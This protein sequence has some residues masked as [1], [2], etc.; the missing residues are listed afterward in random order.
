MT[1]PDVP[2]AEVPLVAGGGCRPHG[3]DRP[4]RHLRGLSGVGRPALKWRTS[5]RPVHHYR[6]RRGRRQIDAA[7]ACWRRRSSGPGSPVR[8]TRE[9]GG[10]PGAEAIR[11]LLL[12]GEGERWDAISEALLLTAARRDHVARVIAR[13]SRK[14]VWVVSRPVSPIRRWPIRVTAKGCRS[15]SSLHCSGFALGDLSARPDRDPRSA[16][17]NRARPRCRALGRRPLRAPRPRFPRKAAPR[18]PPDRRRRSC[19]L[20]VDRRLGRS[21]DGAPRRGRCGRAA[22]GRGVAPHPALSPRAGRGR[23]PRQREGEGQRRRSA[24]GLLGAAREQPRSAW[25][26]GRR[27]GAAPAVRSGRLP[28]AILL[29]GP[30]GIGKATLAFRLARFL[31]AGP[32]A[33]GRRSASAERA[34]SRSIPTSSVFRRVASGGHADLLTVERAY[35]PRRRRLRSEIIVEDAREIAGFFRL[36]AAE[37]GWRIV[38]VDGAEEMNRNAANALPQN[39]R[40]AAAARAAAAGQPQPG[41]AAADD[42]L[43]LPAVSAGCAARGRWS[44]SFSNDIVPNSRRSERR[45]ACASSPTAASAG[46]SNSPTPAGS[47]ST[48]R[49]LEMLAP[50]AADRHRRAACLRR[51]ARPPRGGGRLPGDRGTAVAISRAHGRSRGA[52][53]LGAEEL[54]AGEGEAMRRLAAR[55]DPARWADLRERDRPRA[56]PTPT[57]LNLDRKQAM[58][59]AFFAIEELA[60]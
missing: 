27:A 33:A 16:G 38:I 23:D 45:G 46:R 42:P 40:G 41:P 54:I 31:L 5:T 12:E 47:R 18:V 51:Q 19:P 3:R 59:G 58:L 53:P 34:G 14:G 39:P 29:S 48:A 22:L 49:L 11:R 10:S 9:P 44:C 20:R 32:D 8:A 4:H 26:R 24:T 37:E 7:A 36:T 43:A 17:R 60:R 21:A 50:A 6:G 13:R 2:P 35:D 28:H 55:A 56:S 1:A 15:T 52:R 57:Q 30:R 25:A